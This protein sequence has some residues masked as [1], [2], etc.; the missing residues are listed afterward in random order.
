MTNTKNNLPLYEEQKQIIQE[1]QLNLQQIL[2]QFKQL[3]PADFI[4]LKTLGENYMRST[5]SAW[6]KPIC[7]RYS[8]LNGEEWI[9]LDITHSLL[10]ELEIELG[11]DIPYPVYISPLALKKEEVCKGITI[12]DK[13][14]IFIQKPLIIT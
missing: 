13:K 10:T 11:Q 5:P 3:V 2:A 6:P 12:E 4:E 14:E 7:G 8:F 1:E 9:T